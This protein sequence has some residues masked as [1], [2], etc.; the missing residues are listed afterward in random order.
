MKGNASSTSTPRAT[1]AAAA[2]ADA[3][4][5]AAAADAIAHAAAASTWLLSGRGNAKHKKSFFWD[6]ERRSIGRE[7]ACDFWEAPNELLAF[8]FL[9][10]QKG[11]VRR[12][13]EWILCGL[14]FCVSVLYSHYLQDR[15]G[16]FM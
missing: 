7:P 12:N 9:F 14:F 10:F 5:A 4:A 11:G 3:L 16:K 13:K 6:L 15:E 8:G 1:A 2:A